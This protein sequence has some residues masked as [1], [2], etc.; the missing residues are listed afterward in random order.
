MT[1]MVN[2]KLIITKYAIWFES[3]DPEYTSGFTDDDGDSEFLQKHE[4][5]RRAEYCNKIGIIDGK[6]L[7]KTLEIYEVL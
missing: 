2:R 4:A 1:D 3:N 5:E 7:V 6:Y